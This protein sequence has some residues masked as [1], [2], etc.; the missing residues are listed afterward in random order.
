MSRQGGWLTAS[1]IEKLSLVI[2]KLQE[3]FGVN[4]LSRGH[5]QE[6]ELM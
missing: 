3:R 1:M 2:S 4:C 6:V 5:W